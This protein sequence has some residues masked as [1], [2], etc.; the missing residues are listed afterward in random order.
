MTKLEKL[1]TSEF[2]IDKYLQNV[3]DNFK[4]QNTP[5]Q[6]Y[7]LST[8]TDLFTLP[9]PF[10]RTDYNFLFYLKQGDFVQVIGTES[11]HVQADSFVFVAA[12]VVNSLQKVSKDMAGYFVL[13]KD[14]AMSAFFDREKLLS[15]Y[16]INP[17]FKMNRQ[18]S[19]WMGTLLELLWSE[20]ESDLPNAFIGHGLAQAL[21][22][23][24]LDLSGINK[25]VSRMQ[26]IA[27]EFKILVYQ[28]FIAEKNVSFYADHFSVSESYL[29]R[30][31]KKYFFKSS[32]E[33]ITE[34]AILNSQIML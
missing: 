26:Q 19:S 34:T 17:V 9:I 23:K 20:Y 31:V 10:I 24:V 2:F 5:L 8:L 15:L 7:P 16:I 18:D 3:P 12:G 27:I 28:N 1:I 21:L 4:W 14:E 30:C 13:I 33:I 25:P 11:Y 22:Y 29:N 32:K 6:I